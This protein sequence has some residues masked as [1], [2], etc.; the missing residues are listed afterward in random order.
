MQLLYRVFVLSIIFL[1]TTVFLHAQSLKD[2]KAGQLSES[3]LRQIADK[4]AA[5]QYSDEQLKQLATGQG[6]SQEEAS[7]LIERIREYRKRNSKTSVNTAPA[8]QYN[9][10]VQDSLT[11]PGKEAAKNEDPF[12]IIKPR[13]F[14]ADLFR[15]GNIIFQPDMNM[16]TPAGY[17]IGPGDELLIDLTG[18]NVASYN[19]RV[20]P[21]GFINIEYAGRVNVGGLSIEDGTA[22]IRSAMQGV[23]PAL[24]NGGS[25]VAV[26]LGNIRSIKVTLLGEVNRP[27]SY[28]LSSLSTVFNALYASGGPNENGSF[29]AIEVIRNNDVIA[30]VDIY[31]FLLN[32]RQA[33][34]IRLQDQDVIRVPVFS[35]RVEIAGEVKRPAIYEVLPGE[36]LY[37]VITFAGKFTTQAYKASVKALQNTDIERRVTDIAASGF[38]DYR[39]RNGDKYVVEAILD[40]FENRVEI[41]GAVFRP[42]IFELEPGL[43]L[44]KLIAKAAGL[45]ED[46][47]LQRGYIIRLKPDNS[48]E[49]ISFHIGDLMNGTAPDITLRREDIVQISSIFDLRDE[50]KVTVDGEVRAPGT[51]KY[52]ENMT[53]GSLIQMAGGFKEGASPD[54]IEIARRVK[55]FDPTSTKA[56]TAEIFSMNI[57]QD[58][59]A[60]DRD[61]RIQPFDIITIRNM[62]GYEVQ[63]RIRIE[64]EVLYPG[65][66]TIQN[67]DERVSD[68]IKRAGGLT[69]FAYA[70]GASLNRPDTAVSN[71]KNSIQ[72][73]KKRQEEKLFNFHRLSQDSTETFEET[74]QKQQMLSSSLIGINLEQILSRPHEKNDLILQN[75][76]II[77]VPKL[78]QTVKVNGEVLRPN[79]IVYNGKRSFK[80]YIN[81]AGG[82]TQEALKRG[83]F[84][85]YANGS[86]ASTKKFLFFNNY[87]AV[88]PGAEI[89]VPNRGPKEKVG[90]QGWIAIGTAIVS[91]SAMVFSLLKN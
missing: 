62:A 51:F 48:Q 88:K 78:L 35:T 33:N 85:Q 90:T 63:M 40:R 61:F 69:A 27:G 29:R 28:T 45:K 68:L 76:D 30:T 3:Q 7:L 82:F 43:T 86:V 11:E 6:M 81:G 10:P 83:A 64:G 32:G 80:S 19:L 2:I 52:A 8:R 79:S 42:G 23:Y 9:A 17:I 5:D 73:N 65:T 70:E 72:D 87:P 58:L 74:V 4:A 38:S 20:S 16:P 21:E 47:F 14:G 67:K 34:N 37:D 50:Y 15:D 24:K 77:Q 26:T 55:D 41:K 46:A 89:F 71:G 60:S 56:R 75:G 1:S 57:N 84:I 66:Y 36:S 91:M 39:P 54:R 49:L 13:I 44:S 59:S 25:K 12:E 18:D 22:K 53:L 31:D